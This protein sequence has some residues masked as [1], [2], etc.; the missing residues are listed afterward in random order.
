MFIV[1]A[2]ASTTAFAAQ[3]D[4]LVFQ[5]W[6]CKYRLV[7]IDDDDN[8]DVIQIHYFTPDASVSSDIDA[9]Y[10]IENKDLV[11]IVWTDDDGTEYSW[12]KGFT[13]PEQAATTSRENAAIISF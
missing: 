1:L 6:D 3:P 8:P 10:L 12:T 13:I 7:D 9:Y 11:A 4:P 5:Q 2:I